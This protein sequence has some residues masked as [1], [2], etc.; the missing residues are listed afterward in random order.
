MPF[1]PKPPASILQ[2][3]SDCQMVKVTIPLVGGKTLHLDGVI[4]EL[5]DTLLDIRFPE[6]ALPVE[7]IAQEGRWRITFDK[8]LSFLNVW[9]R[10][11]QLLSPHRVQLTVTGSDSS[12]YAR[13]DHRV[14][15]EIY[16]RYWQAGDGRQELAPQ[17]I[18]V[19]L[20]GCGISFMTE[21]PLMPN[22]LVELELFLPGGTLERVRCVGRVIRGSGQQEHHSLTAL[23]LINLSQADV[24]KIINFCMTEQFRDMQQKA[25]MLAATI[26]PDNN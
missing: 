14:N 12:Q 15:T 6:Q 26:G 16:L 25:R 20:S 22:S 24:E 23:E 1:S 7:K 2:D 17:R 10:L 8:G 13:R 4:K 18:Q 11:T 5:S 19:N 21:T 9:A 3:F